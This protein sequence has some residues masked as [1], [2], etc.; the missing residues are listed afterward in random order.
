V[1]KG[2]YMTQVFPK[3]FNLA[4]LDGRNGF[5]IKGGGGPVSSAGDVNGDGIKDVIIGTS[6]VFGSKSK[7]SP[8]FNLQSLN[9]TNGFVFG[10]NYESSNYKSVDSAGDVNGDGIDDIIIGAP[11]ISKYAGQSY[12]VFG[13]KKAYP[14]PFGVQNLNGSNGFIINGVQDYSYSGSSVSSAGDVNGD[15]IDDIIIGA[16]SASNNAGQSYVVFGSKSGFPQIFNLVNLD[17]RNGFTINGKPSD[18]SGIS[19][20]RAG[21][22]NHDGIVDIIIGAYGF[23]SDAGKSYVVFGSKVGFLQPFNLANLDGRN[24]FVINGIKSGGTNPGDQSGNSV[25]NAG[26]INGDGI[27]DVIIGTN[28]ARQCY[29]VF[30]SKVGFPASLNLQN[31]DGVNGFAVNNIDDYAYSK[32]H[33]SVSRAGDINNDGIDDIIIGTP[34]GSNTMPG[35]P[36]ATGPGKS[37]IVFGREVGFPASFDL[38]YLDGKNGFN[39]NGVDTGDFSGWSVSGAGDVNG[40]GVSDVIIGAPGQTGSSI[41]PKSY[42]VFG[43]SAGGASSSTGEAPSSTGT[44]VRPDSRSSALDKFLTIG[45]PILSAIAAITG[46]AWTLWQCKKNGAFCFKKASPVETAM[47]SQALLPAADAWST[48]EKLVDKAYYNE[49]QTSL[50]SG[51]EIMF[52]EQDYG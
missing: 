38:K 21:D 48:N 13:S 22:I 50:H 3:D 30:G 41:S 19:V 27:N 18:W 7:F 6:V 20:S 15:G 44:D 5:V 17:G 39:I 35:P 25:S 52:I 28:Q 37:Y 36:P 8:V 49:D 46:T 51:N 24:G 23:S 12:V 47:L 32:S 10:S 9:G 31:L 2:E 16:P 11:S 26:D 42:V 4:N 1:I 33:K 29:V 40:D 43:I 45:V 34:Q 14:Q